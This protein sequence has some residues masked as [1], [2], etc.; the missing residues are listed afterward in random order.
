MTDWWKKPWFEAVNDI[1]VLPTQQEDKNLLL[2]ARKFPVEGSQDW[3]EADKQEVFDP[4][5]FQLTEDVEE[6]TALSEPE[7]EEY[8]DAVVQRP[9]LTTSV[10]KKGLQLADKLVDHL[11]DIDNF[12]DRCLRYKMKTVRELSGNI[13]TFLQGHAEEGKAVKDHLFLH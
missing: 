7:D 4:Q 12:T 3:K 5:V 6:L 1:R 8:S 2:L 9:R 10:M 11:F 13:Q